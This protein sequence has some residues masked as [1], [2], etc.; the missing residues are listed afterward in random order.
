MDKTILLIQ[1]RHGT[2]GI[3]VNPGIP[4]S[5]LAIAAPLVERNYKVIII[6]QAADPH[7]K[8][9]LLDAL[10]SNLLCIGITC[11]TG[12]QITHAA[13]L[14]DLIKSKSK[15]PLV[16]GGNHATALPAQ[17]LAYPAIDYVVQ[18]EG[19]FS[20]LELISALEA[21]RI[22]EGI[23]GVWYKVDNIPRA[24]PRRP[25]CDLDKLPPIPYHIIFSKNDTFPRGPGKRINIETSR[26]C[27]YKCTFCYNQYH[28]L[29]Q[30]RAMS[31][32][33]ALDRIAEATDVFHSNSIFIVDDN[34]FLDL[35]RSKEIAEGMIRMKWNLDWHA[36]GIDIRS[37]D[38]MDDTFLKLLRRSGCG[39]LKFGVESGSERILKLINKGISVEQVIRVNRKL[40]RYDFI[41]YYSF[42]CGFPDET[43][44]E[45]RQTIELLLALRK[46]NPSA[47]TTMLYIYSPYP[48]TDLYDQLEA[49][50]VTFPKRLVDW[51]V[52]DRYNATRA[53]IPKERAKLLEGL[54]F[55]SI[56]LDKESI[57]MVK[58]RIVRVLMRLYR[59]IARWRLRHLNIRMLWEKRFADLIMG[60]E[61]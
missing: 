1:P 55:V 31:A 6:D 45:L 49:K 36:Q 12:S 25:F 29:S 52:M 59:S 8:Q 50:G 19:E 14:S 53:F 18:G 38:K 15:A 37:A 10:D 43:M 56:F 24:N 57:A 26:G 28:N 47:N 20:F 27:P 4:L 32:D 9:T 61:R 41:P 30:W 46:D 39:V 21:G 16:W 35:Q 44:E 3:S 58:W 23:P 2:Y 33:S 22:I 42:M 48:G 13:R 11:K 54:S 51:A 5:L 60:R 17:T 7:W 40:S 34:F